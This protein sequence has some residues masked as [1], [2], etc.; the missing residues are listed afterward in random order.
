M[1]KK[2]KVYERKLNGGDDVKSNCE[3]HG[4]PRIIKM[5]PQKTGN[6]GDIIVSD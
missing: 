4:P 6:F 3:W 1:R 5:T 2:V